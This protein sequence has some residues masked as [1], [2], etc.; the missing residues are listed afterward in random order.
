M[1]KSPYSFISLINSK[2]ILKL[3]IIIS[4]IYSFPVT[5]DDIAS[6]HKI[7]AGYLYN[8]TKFITWSIP[9]TTSFNVCVL[10]DSEF[11]EIL[12]PIEQHQVLTKPIKIY[13][14]DSIHQI[15]K[16]IHCHIL[17]INDSITELP[18]NYDISDTLIVGDDTNF[19]TR[20]GMISF[21]IVDDR[22][23]L[24]INPDAIKA[25]SLKVSAKL[26]EVAYI[27]TAR[28]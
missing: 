6:V 23:K 22:V 8:F 15:S 3:F 26:L 13:Q 11:A 10:R 5:A 20:G 18:A 17:F 24:Q 4:I 21:V 7:K 27:V 9:I 1:I 16:N 19:I 25:S 2:C 12:K 14:Y 28:N